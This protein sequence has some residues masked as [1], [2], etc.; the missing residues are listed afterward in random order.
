MS[1]QDTWRLFP[2][3]AEID[4]S[5]RLWLGGC[6]ARE[7]AVQYGTPL[8]VF[9][10]ATLVARAREAQAVLVGEGRS[11]LLQRRETAAELLARDVP[12]DP[13]A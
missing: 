13:P 1:D 7:L 8:Y 9:D 4:P 3:G 5:G 10:K 11:R 6:L 2:E 12:L